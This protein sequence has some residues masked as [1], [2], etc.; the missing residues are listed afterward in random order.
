MSPPKTFIPAASTPTLCTFVEP[1]LKFDAVVT[2]AALI[3]LSVI[4]SEPV[5]TVRIPVTLAL[6][7]TT[8]FSECVVSPPTLT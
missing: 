3:S 6:P 4:V 1:V 8:N 2:P 5:P 7:V